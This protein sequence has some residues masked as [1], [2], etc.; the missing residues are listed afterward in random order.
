MATSAVGSGEGVSWRWGGQHGAAGMWGG[1]QGVVTGGD[2][3]ELG[4]AVAAG[5]GQGTVW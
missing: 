2:R 5:S 3:A 4:L 1:R